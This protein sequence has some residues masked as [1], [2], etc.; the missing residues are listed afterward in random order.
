MK[1]SSVRQTA[2]SL[3]LTAALVTSGLAYH[4]LC[5]CCR[6][7][8]KTQAAMPDSGSTSCGCALEAPCTEDKEC[9]CTL[10][11]GNELPAQFLPLKRAILIRPSYYLPMT[12]VMVS[13]SPLCVLAPMAEAF[14]ASQP[15]Y[16]KVSV[17]A[18]LCRFLC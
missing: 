9:S 13:I 11:C 17:E 14:H 15:G 1:Y 2:L 10:S 5:P 4:T 16:L 6:P 18:F 3:V 7:S 8:A 12:P